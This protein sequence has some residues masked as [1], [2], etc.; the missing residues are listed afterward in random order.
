MQSFTA[1]DAKNRFGEVIDAALQGPVSITK[2]NRPSVV[3]MSDAEYRALAQ[4]KYEALKS[5]VQ[6]GFDQLDQGKA[7][8]RTPR[9]I[10]EDVRRQFDQ[11]EA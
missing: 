2:H 3:V 4:A 11:G 6:I 8:S 5:E 9:Q 7:A 1:N 10:A